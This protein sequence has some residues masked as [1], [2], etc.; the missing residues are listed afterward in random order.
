MFIV[1]QER[2][3]VEK[4]KNYVEPA[5]AD[6]F[7][8]N[9]QLKTRLETFRKLQ[10]K[11]LDAQITHSGTMK[12]KE[13]MLLAKKEFMKIYNKLAVED[14]K[15]RKK[16]LSEKVDDAPLTDFI[17]AMKKCFSWGRMIRIFN[18]SAKDYLP[19]GEELPDEYNQEMAK[20]G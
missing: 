5:L 6:Y 15:E 13:E 7:E 9:P 19:D 10:A 3:A 18:V 2:A 8:K 16:T 14:L 12:A 17:G 1:L 11:W 20:K 4:S